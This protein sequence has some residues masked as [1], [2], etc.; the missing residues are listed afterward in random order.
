MRSGRSDRCHFLANHLLLTMSAKRVYHRLPDLAASFRTMNALAACK[1]TAIN[2]SNGLNDLYALNALNEFQTSTDFCTSITDN[3]TCI[4][5]RCVS[6]MSNA[7]FH[8]ASGIKCAS[9]LEALL[10]HG[11]ASAQSS[12]PQYPNLTTDE[13]TFKLNKGNAALESCVV[14]LSS[15]YCGNG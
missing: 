5:R 13:A 8:V 9:G 3:A 4:L 6:F 1:F 2:E 15:Q 7:I 12:R 11:K 10:S 14:T